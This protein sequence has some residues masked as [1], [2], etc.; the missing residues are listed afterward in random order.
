MPKNY[1][2]FD[3]EDEAARAVDEHRR[4]LGHPDR[5]SRWNFDELGRPAHDS[6]IERVSCMT[7][8]KWDERK[9]RWSV[10]NEQL[11]G[12]ER[13]PGAGNHY[14]RTLQEAEAARSAFVTARDTCAK[15]MGS[16]DTGSLAGK[17]RA[18]GG[19]RTGR[20]SMPG[21]GSGQDDSGEQGALPVPA[22]AWAGQLG[23]S[24]AGMEQD[25]M[26]ELLAGVAARRG[27]AK[28]SALGR[29]AK[30]GWRGGAV[31]ENL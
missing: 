9:W 26:L 1:S 23:G 20:V 27:S 6:S 14:F 12:S 31:Q 4:K 22:V 10:R 5:A 13:L 15:A 29:R 2:L 16:Q 28:V 19:S 18:R 21:G 25:G 17:K 3:T 24:A 30:G 7:G 8:V 11:S